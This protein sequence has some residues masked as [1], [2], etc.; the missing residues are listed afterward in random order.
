[1]SPRTADYLFRV[2]RMKL[3]PEE[4]RRGNPVKSWGPFEDLYAY[5]AYPT[6][7]VDVR[8]GV[9]VATVTGYTVVAPLTVG[10]GRK[11][12]V[13][14]PDIGTFE[15]IGKPAR[16]THNPH[17]PTSDNLGVEIKLEEVTG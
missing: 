2:S 15:V 6:T 3:G 7:S 16:W 4:D 8:D 5:T 12:R 13:E 9:A 10:V 1:M 17:D 11:D 14:L